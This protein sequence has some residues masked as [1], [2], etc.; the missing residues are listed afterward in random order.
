[1]GATLAE[2]LFSAR[3]CALRLGVRA[4]PS[5]SCTSNSDLSY[6][7]G[8]G[9]GEGKAFILP[10]RYP[11]LSAGCSLPEAAS[12]NPQ[13]ALY[14][15]PVFCKSSPPPYLC[16]LLHLTFIRAAGIA[17]VRPNKHTCPHGTIGV[18]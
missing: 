10:S 11:S 9:G 8:C 7:L 16:I 14:G 17:R 12:G 18:G 1:M 3:Y 6:T 5:A 13:L 15:A 4:S 2:A